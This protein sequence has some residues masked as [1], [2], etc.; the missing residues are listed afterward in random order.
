MASETPRYVSISPLLKRLW[1]SPGSQNVTAS[2]IAAAVSLIFEDRLSP[3]QAGA[4]LTCL[5]FTEWDIRA[6]VLASCATAM[7]AAAF[8][9]DKTELQRVVQARQRAEGDYLGGLVSE[10]MWGERWTSD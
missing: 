5:H 10:C 6:D 2:E 1:P 9:V 8:P 3:V 4:L 7:R